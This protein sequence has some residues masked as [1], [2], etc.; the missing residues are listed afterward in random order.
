VNK[1]Q[2]I[3]EFQEKGLDKIGDFDSPN[4]KHSLGSSQY[5]GVWSTM[6]AFKKVRADLPIEDVLEIFEVSFEK[7][8]DFKKAKQKLLYG[9]LEDIKFSVEDERFDFVRL[10]ADK[11][12]PLSNAKNC[13]EFFKVLKSRYCD[14]WSSAP[15]VAKCVF[16][17]LEIGNIYSVNGIAGVCCA[18]LLEYKLVSD[19][20]FL[21]CFST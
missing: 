19:V 10:G 5:D 3:K 15:R 1:E 6:V 16:E 7:I 17:G 9:V 2:W 4:S 8:N 13:D 11:L 14:L 21:A 12:V 18:L 20:K